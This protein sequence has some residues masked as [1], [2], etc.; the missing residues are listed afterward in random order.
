GGI[1][2]AIYESLEKVYVALAE[3]PGEVDE[4]TVDRVLAL[5]YPHILFALEQ[6]ISDIASDLVE[7]VLQWNEE[8]KFASKFYEFIDKV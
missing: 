1:S 3:W 6:D 4:A 5:L 8:G 7:A 2:S